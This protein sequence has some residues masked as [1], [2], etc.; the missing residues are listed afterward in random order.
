MPARTIPLVPHQVYHV[1][2]K[3]QGNEALFS[4]ASL[5]RLMLKTIWYYQFTKLPMKLSYYRHLAISERTKISSKITMSAR[6]VNILAYCLMPNH[7]HLLLRQNTAEGISTFMSNVQNSIT[8]Y[9]NIKRRTEG[10]VFIGQFKAVRVETDELLLHISRYIHL[11]PYT[12]YVVKNFGETITYP[13]SSC[14]EYVTNTSGICDQSL[15]MSHFKNKQAYAAFV[16][17]QKDYQRTL[18]DIKGYLFNDV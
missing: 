18:A 15:I 9:A 10:H 4:R 7:Y 8:R 2:N 17:D 1:F 14:A 3:T 5:S 13:W 11:N 12:G 16:Y 6:H